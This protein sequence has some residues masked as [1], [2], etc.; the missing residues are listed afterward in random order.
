[1]YISLGHTI[2][3]LCFFLLCDV[4]QNNPERE[5]QNIFYHPSSVNLDNVGASS[6]FSC[7]KVSYTMMMRYGVCF[8][9]VVFHPK[10]WWL[11]VKA[12]REMV[13]GAIK[14]HLL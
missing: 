12:N 4:L 14:L 5:L 6:S 3:K 13:N 8:V 2:S 9:S 1:M 7:L 10:L 11:L